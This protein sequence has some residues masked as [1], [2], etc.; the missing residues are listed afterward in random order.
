MG[1][2]GFSGL[3]AVTD[4]LDEKPQKLFLEENF[5]DLV[6][7]VYFK[8]TMDFLELNTA[9]HVR[10][11][12]WQEFRQLISVLQQTFLRLQSKV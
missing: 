8:S 12:L 6:K 11:S 4:V 7:H 3:Y 5:V 9:N 2:C 10:L 1:W